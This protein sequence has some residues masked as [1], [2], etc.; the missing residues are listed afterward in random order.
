MP[1]RMKRSNERR[2]I[3]FKSWLLAL[4]VV[5]GLSVAAFQFTDTWRLSGGWPLGIG[6][7]E[8]DA[9]ALL[10]DR[11]SEDTIHHRVETIH[12][13]LG[14][15]SGNCMMEDSG[16]G[17]DVRWLEAS[18]YGDS[19]RVRP[20]RSEPGGYVVRMREGSYLREQRS[21]T[22]RK[23]DVNSIQQKY[24]EMIATE[25][26]LLT[27]ELTLVRLVACGADQGV[28]VKEEVVNDH[29]LQRRGMQD[30]LAFTCWF[31]PRIG[32]SLTP[33]IARDTAATASLQ[34]WWNT[35]SK[36]APKDADVAKGIDLDQLANWLL[37][38]WLGG[39]E[40][41]LTGEVAMAYRWGQR[42]VV[43]IHR[44]ARKGAQELG[45]LSTYRSTPITSLLGNA[46]LR[47]RFRAAQ[48]A[49]VA[50]RGHLRER[51]LA[52]TAIW[53]PLLCNGRNTEIE[54]ARAARLL[55]TILDVRLSDRS[56]MDGLMRPL[57]P[58]PGMGAASG[59]P[60]LANAATT[61]NA[62]LGF[63]EELQRMTK[64]RVTADSVIFPRGKYRIDKDLVLPSGRSVV[65]LPG[66]RL[67]LG[68]GV[69]IQCRGPLEILGTRIN[70]V[71]IRPAREG[72]PFVGLDVVGD[73]AGVSRINGLQM[74]GGGAG[75]AASLSVQGMKQ[76]TIQGCVLDGA[77]GEAVL[78]I[79][80]G[81]VSME[82]GTIE[83]G[84]LEL[85]QVQATL[86]GLSIIGSTRKP[87]PASI[88]LNGTRARLQG[89]TW[90]RCAG[91]A[92]VL[93]QAS[94]ALILN[95]RFD[96]NGTALKATDGSQVHVDGSILT[97]NGLV[98]D[99]NSTGSTRGATRLMLYTNE[100]MGNTKDRS[101]D[102]ISV[103]QEGLRLSDAVRNGSTF[104]P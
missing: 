40:L 29:F 58:V 9:Y 52:L 13:G 69:R 51:M 32:Y 72:D 70:P 36:E 28:H 56:A 25:L 87:G 97:N 82:G 50:E 49:M 104:I 35:T 95:G 85:T 44:P 39:E 73:G 80:G 57:E 43:P 83:R 23:A 31:D 86:K 79:V 59:S 88:V 81:E 17:W 14:G 67:E 98:F 15:R 92:L 21:F 75:G 6:A 26:G 78:H 19:V 60:A 91:V 24:L 2:P 10:M 18:G 103:V 54:K 1:L 63:L 47:E 8:V 102:V 62:S 96:G 53:V 20:M 77:A 84:S 90:G 30:G 34:E 61:P 12:I 5:G 41:A 37:V 64:L 74:S 94:Q 3:G 71:F 22:L 68:P 4:V 65:M 93:E 55:H 38:Q 48:E 27:P 66:A 76:I 89:I 99:L 45:P 11:S 7:N 16:R 100:F 46:E 33:V 101:T 42:Q